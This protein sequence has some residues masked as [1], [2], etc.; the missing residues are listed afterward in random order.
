MAEAC[1]QLGE[2]V[3]CVLRCLKVNEPA[4]AVVEEASD[5]LKAVASLAETISGSLHGET[6]D[7]LAYMIDDELTAMDKAIEE[8]AR[9]IQVC[10][11]SLCHQYFLPISI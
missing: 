9:S 2:T 1:K 7:N 6:A 4:Q 8:A 10:P 3:L 11:L 5:K